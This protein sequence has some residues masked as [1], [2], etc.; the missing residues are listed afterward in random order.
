MARV[1]VVEPIHQ[2]GL[3]ILRRRSGIVVEQLGQTNEAAIA[4]GAR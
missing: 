3:D 1:L 2:S 4:A